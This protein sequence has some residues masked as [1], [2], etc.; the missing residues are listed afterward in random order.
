[1]NDNI[2]NKQ[3]KPTSRKQ[4]INMRLALLGDE[5]TRINKDKIDILALMVELKAEYREI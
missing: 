2:Y 3:V 4:Y 1:M 5:L